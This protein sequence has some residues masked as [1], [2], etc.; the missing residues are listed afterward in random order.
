MPQQQAGAAIVETGND[1]FEREWKYFDTEKPT[2][3][4]SVRK[5]YKISGSQLT[6]SLAQGTTPE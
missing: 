6:G 3:S 5:Y 4:S 1:L 2:D